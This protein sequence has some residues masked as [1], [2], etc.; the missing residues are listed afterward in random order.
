MFGVCLQCGALLCEWGVDGTGESRVC[1]CV[2]VSVCVC[3]CV[4]VCVRVCVQCLC[5]CVCVC[6]THL[7]TFRLRNVPMTWRNMNMRG[8]TGFPWW[9]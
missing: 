4:C 8:H 9:V 3:V 5:V 7:F 1:V 2:C 6:V